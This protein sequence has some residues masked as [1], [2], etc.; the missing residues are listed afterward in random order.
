MPKYTYECAECK[1]SFTCHHSIAD[2]LKECSKCKLDSLVRKPS[3]FST[4][5]EEEQRTNVGDLVERAIKD[6]KTELNNEKRT[7]KEKMWS[8][9]D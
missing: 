9:D 7:L 4:K 5:R 1:D 2:L 6:F 3:S 8:P